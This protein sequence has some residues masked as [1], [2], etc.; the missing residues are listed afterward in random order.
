LL[1]EQI[2]SFGIGLYELVYIL[3]Y[4]V[5][6]QKNRDPCRK[7]KVLEQSVKAIR[8]FMKKK[9]QTTPTYF[10]Q[11]VDRAMDILACFT[12]KEKERTLAEIVQQTRLNRTTA[13]RLLFHLT[14]RNYLMYNDRNRTYQL[15]IKLLELGGIALSSISLRKIAA[16][17][18][19]RL[20]NDLGHTILL[21]VR[22]EDSLVYIDKRD[23]KGVM[24]VTSEIGRIRPLHFGMLGMVLMAHLPRQEQ[25]DLL[26]KNPLKPYTHASITD[27]EEFLRVL[28]GI[29]EK[30]YYVGRQDVF[31]GVGGVSAPVRDF[32]GHVV[33]ALG[34]TMMLSLFDRPEVEA[35]ALEKV[36]ETVSTISNDLGYQAP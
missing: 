17:Y 28:S 31:E 30:G 29:K 33:A 34:F 26:K 21:G 14:S 27:N 8:T 20:R 15:G 18:L 12:F 23:G 10:V 7:N 2:T 13:T 4:Y 35:E 6:T 3:R 24:V 32:R 11:S 16:P 36:K 5:L 22:M 9:D 25:E 19:T 1:N